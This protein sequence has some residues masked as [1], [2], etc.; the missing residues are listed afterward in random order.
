MLIDSHVLLWIL[1]DDER[2]GVRARRRLAESAH[3]HVSS[4]SVLELTIKKMLGRLTFPDDF[5]AL[6]TQEGL[7]HAPWAAEDADGIRQFPELIRHD[8]FDRALLAQAA[9]HGWEFMTADERILKLGL[10]WL[11]DA[12][13]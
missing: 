2:L 9:R 4:V 10:P 7:Q 3:V 12:R 1:T 5:P 13:A 8:P 11:V 6:I